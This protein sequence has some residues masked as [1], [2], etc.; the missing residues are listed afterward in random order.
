MDLRLFFNGVLRL[1]QIDVDDC[2]A[3][4]CLNGGECSDRVDGFECRC[5]AGFRGAVC[6]AR[7]FCPPL[8]ESTPSGSFRWPATEF[9]LTARLPCPFG[10]KASRSRRSGQMRKPIPCQS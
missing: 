7:Q 3:D 6:E 2:Q 5:R 8:A 10:V 1:D 9:G 4:P